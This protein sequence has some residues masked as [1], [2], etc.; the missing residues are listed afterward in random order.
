MKTLSDCKRQVLIELD[1]ADKTLQ[2][3]TQPTFGRPRRGRRIE[4]GLEQIQNGRTP[5][6]RALE[7]DPDG[8]TLSRLK[9]AHVNWKHRHN[10]GS[11]SRVVGQPLQN[12]R[13]FHAVV[14]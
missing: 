14:I 8:K 10:I 12:Q 7:A 6:Q 4:E 9:Q 2:T 3:T 5:R 11:D 13:I 1:Q